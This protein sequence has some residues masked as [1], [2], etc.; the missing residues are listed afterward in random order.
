MPADS[1]RRRAEPTTTHDAAAAG[2]LPAARALPDPAAAVAHCRTLRDLMRWS[3][4]RLRAAGAAYGQGTADAWDDAAWLL[5]WSLHLPPE[6]LDPVMDARLS[7][8]EVAQAVALVERRCTERVPVAYLTGE[9]WLRGVRFLAD[10]RAIVPRSLLAE[11][12][13]A[14]LEDWLPDAPADVLDL[15]TGGGSLA[16]L[17]A[18]RFPDA[19]VVGVDVDAAP[20]ALARENAR[21]HDVDGRIEWRQGDLWAPL[22]ERRFELVLCNPPYVNA[23]SMRALPPEFRA[24]PLHALAGGDDGMALVRRILADAHRHLAPDGALLLEIG[25]EAAG[26]EAAFPRLEH[27]W[28]PVSAGERMVVLVDARSLRAHA[29]APSGGARGAAPRRRRAR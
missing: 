15:C 2:A 6:R 25:H 3:T 10:A 7:P 29:E 26:F 18:L 21:L 19:R 14:S 13:D 9:A 11:V 22:D 12:L 4:S 20:L 28:V 5:L 27:A 8:A 1:R 23:R 16:V 24:E 17:A